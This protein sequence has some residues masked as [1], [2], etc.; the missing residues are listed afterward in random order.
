MRSP[1][2]D[3]VPQEVVVMSGK[4]HIHDR[5]CRC[6]CADQGYLEEVTVNAFIR[7]MAIGFIEGE[8]LAVRSHVA[9]FHCLHVEQHD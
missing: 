1:A 8:R 7:S 2:A 4:R 6:I 9:V 3:I 5:L